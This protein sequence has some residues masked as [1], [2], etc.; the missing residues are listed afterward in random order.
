MAVKVSAAMIVKNAA[1]TIAECLAK[2]A[3]GVDEIVF[4]DT[5]STDETLTIVRNLRDTV[6]MKIRLFNEEWIGD[7][8]A[9]RN[10]AIAKCTGDWILIV[11]SDELVHSEDWAPML[12]CLN[13]GALENIDYVL[14]DCLNV[15]RAYRTVYS[16][17]AQFRWFRK[18]MGEYAGKVHNQLV[19]KSNRIARLPFRLIHLGY[20]L[21]HDKFV[22]KMNRVEAMTRQAVVEAPDSG[23]AKYNLANCLKSYGNEYI[24]EHYDEFKSLLTEGYNIC[25]PNPQQ[26]HIA[27]QC[28][29]LFAWVN[30]YCKKYPEA[31]EWGHK[32]LALKK[33]FVDAILVIGYAN[34]DSYKVD[35]AEYWLKEYLR[36]LEAHT[37]EEK[38]DDTQ[39]VYDMLDEKITVYK[40][41]IAIEVHRKQK[42]V[43]T[44]L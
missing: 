18:D 26:Q 11:D 34:A 16:R 12:H 32:A 42:E 6:G 8:S 21:P 29:S 10:S 44:E 14:C 24:A 5:G 33:D 38:F 1:D 13:N 37:K 30:Y 31:I 3:P 25:L 2:L 40:T 27:M 9:A 15:K 19:L 41:L 17:L 7:F 20:D 4:V 36:E 35:D 28:A 39:V 23:F 43:A 22:E